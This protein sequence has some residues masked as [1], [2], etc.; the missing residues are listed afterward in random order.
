MRGHVKNNEL[1]NIVPKTLVLQFVCIF[2]AV[3]FYFFYQI[4]EQ[5]LF[6][7]KFTAFIGSVS[8]VA[9]ISSATLQ[10][11]CSKA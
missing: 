11:E 3:Q 9:S 7:Q 4:S 2:K 6:V 8:F 1:Q 10:R 5:I